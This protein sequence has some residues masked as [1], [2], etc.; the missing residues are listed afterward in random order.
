MSD[1][2]LISLTR[3]F[4][5]GST[6][7]VFIRVSAITLVQKLPGAWGGRMRPV[8]VSLSTGTDVIV[9]EDLEDVIAYGQD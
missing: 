9:E 5:D 4:E 3:I 1:I 6:T 8:L 7:E 2:E